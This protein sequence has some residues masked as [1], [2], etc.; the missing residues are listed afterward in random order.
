MTDE[1]K[2]E[3]TVA[4]IRTYICLAMADVLPEDI[5]PEREVEFVNFSADIASRIE[6]H[7]NGK[8]P[9]KQEDFALHKLVTTVLDGRNMQERYTA[10]SGS[11]CIKRR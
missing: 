2:Y 5:S 3:I 10:N 8:K 11:K 9:F 1:K 4:D 7:L 6:K